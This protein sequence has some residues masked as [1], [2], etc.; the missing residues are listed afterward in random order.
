M[1][2]AGNLPCFV[3]LA[4]GLAGVSKCCA[5]LYYDDGGNIAEG[6]RQGKRNIGRYI[7]YAVLLWLSSSLA[8][9][10]IVW[11]PRINLPDVAVVACVVV[12]VV[13]FVIVLGWMFACAV[14]NLF[15]EDKLSDIFANGIKILFTKPL[16]IVGFALLAVVPFGIAALLPF[17]W[18]LAAWTMI[19]VLLPVGIVLTVTVNYKKVFDKIVGGNK[20]DGKS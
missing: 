2:C 5:N 4:V 1:W 6:F 14:Q 12:A 8:V 10:S 19:L 7:L 11:S 20:P 13:Q 9:L 17:V 16:A 15:Y 3:L 18:Q